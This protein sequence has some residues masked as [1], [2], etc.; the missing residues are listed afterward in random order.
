LRFLYLGFFFFKN[1]CIAALVDEVVPL[2]LYVYV[3]L[4]LELTLGNSMRKVGMVNNTTV[5]QER[6]QIFES[7]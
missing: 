6:S 2:C 3:Y 1:I 7:Y 5:S 4:Y